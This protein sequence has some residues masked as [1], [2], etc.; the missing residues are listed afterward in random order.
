MTRDPAGA[1]IPRDPRLPQA[2]EIRVPGRTVRHAID[3]NALPMPEVSTPH[4]IASMYATAML[5]L[6]ASLTE[7]AILEGHDRIEVLVEG[8]ET[9]VKSIPNWWTETRKRIRVEW[10]RRQ[11]RRR[12]DRGAS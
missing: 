8:R 7:T 1:E 6:E 5:N 9:V 11:Y 4:S 12:Q 3:W 2:I 10:A